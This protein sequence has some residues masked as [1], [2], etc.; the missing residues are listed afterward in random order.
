MDKKIYVLKSGGT[1]GIYFDWL[2]FW[3]NKDAI[4]VK[5]KIIVYK[6]EYE[7]ADEN[8]KYSK[9]WALAQ[10][11]EYLGEDT[12]SNYQKR[13]KKDYDDD[14]SYFWDMDEPIDESIEED[15]IV[16][17]SDSLTKS[18]ISCILRKMVDERFLWHYIYLDGEDVFAETAQ[19]AIGAVSDNEK[20]VELVKR[21]VNKLLDD[22]IRVMDNE[23]SDKGESCLERIR[24]E[25]DCT[26]CA[27]EIRQFY[28]GFKGC[29]IPILKDTDK[30]YEFNIP[31]KTKLMI[32]SDKERFLDI[33]RAKNTLLAVIDHTYGG[34][35]VDETINVLDAIKKENPALPVYIL[36]CSDNNYSD[37]EKAAF[38]SN[39]AEGFLQDKK[40]A[41][42][43]IK[44][45]WDCCRKRTMEILSSRGQVLTYSTRIELSKDKTSA[46]ITLY[47]LKLLKT[48][49]VYEVEN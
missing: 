49:E 19:Y 22:L 4:N 27:E 31:N 38:M 46:K 42:Q 32:V 26:S 23:T 28:T 40:L 41:K 5:H 15:S 14:Y 29:T 43:I 16:I 39:G 3:E 8:T 25:C 2:G 48:Q 17:T 44:A 47:D 37:N 18:D 11:R 10:A 1:P 13:H 24:L 30:D 21:L 6:T 35:A 34:D 9:A 45:Y 36:E 33:V 20:A 7:D 12:I